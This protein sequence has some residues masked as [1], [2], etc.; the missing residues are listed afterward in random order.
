MVWFSSEKFVLLLESANNINKWK[1]I[2]TNKIFVSV[3]FVSDFILNYYH[4]Y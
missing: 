3:S 2:N 4:V 1:K